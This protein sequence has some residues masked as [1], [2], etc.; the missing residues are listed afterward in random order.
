M[1]DTD[2]A[3]PDTRELVLAALHGAELSP[4]PVHRP[5]REDVSGSVPGLNSPELTAALTAAA[6]SQGHGVDAP[7]P[8]TPPPA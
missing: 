5:Q 6:V 3:C 1:N 8:V 2:C 4:C 7:E